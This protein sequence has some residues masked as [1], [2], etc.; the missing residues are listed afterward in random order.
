MRIEHI[1]PVRGSI[2]LRAIDFTVENNVKSRLKPKAS[3]GSERRIYPLGQTTLTNAEIADPSTGKGIV[4]DVW[5]SKH[6]F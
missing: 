1:Q 4:L 2:V 5:V 3:A 6:L